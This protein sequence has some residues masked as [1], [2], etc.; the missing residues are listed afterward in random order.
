MT[1]SSKLY[2]V[3]QNVCDG[4]SLYFSH[5]AFLLWIQSLFTE[6]MA[7]HLLSEN[8]DPLWTVRFANWS[9]EVQ[10]VRSLNRRSKT[11]TVLPTIMQRE[12]CNLLQRMSSTLH[13]HRVGTGDL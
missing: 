8:A 4:Q 9:E 1:K 12:A 7:L 11:S 13:V 2:H 10:V 3:D 6:Q 5:D